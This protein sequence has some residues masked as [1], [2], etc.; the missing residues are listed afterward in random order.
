MTNDD[1]DQ[2]QPDE[3]T[4]R[5]ITEAQ[6]QV[7][8][9]ALWGKLHDALEREQFTGPLHGAHYAGER[10]AAIARTATD[11]AGA[12]AEEAHARGKRAFW[13]G[14]FSDLAE[15]ATARAEAAR[16]DMTRHGDPPVHAPR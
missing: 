12:T 10:A 7:R 14:Y 8:L 3:Q 16:D 15:E 6:Q 4:A 2:P 11:R 9:P 1:E 13:V 5:L